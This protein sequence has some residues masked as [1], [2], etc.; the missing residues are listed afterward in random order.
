M[1]KK[2]FDFFS[3]NATKSFSERFALNPFAGLEEIKTNLDLKLLNSVNNEKIQIYK[4]RLKQNKNNLRESA[5]LGKN[6]F[7]NITHCNTIK[8]ITVIKTITTIITV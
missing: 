6:W 3:L 4:V 7:T 2:T 1:K 5:A 8:T